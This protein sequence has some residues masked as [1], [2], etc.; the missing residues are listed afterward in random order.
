MQQRTAGG[1]VD[2]RGLSEHCHEGQVGQW[3]ANGAQLPVQHG[4]H[5]RLQSESRDNI[6]T[7]VQ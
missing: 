3:M 1:V 7:H 5:T 4:D 2:G 6:Y